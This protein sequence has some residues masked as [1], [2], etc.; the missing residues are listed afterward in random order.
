MT[1][2]VQR[3]PDLILKQELAKIWC[4][5]PDEVEINA[6]ELY[7]ATTALFIYE[8]TYSDLAERIS[9]VHDLTSTV[10]AVAQRGN[11]WGRYEYNAAQA[12]HYLATKYHSYI[13]DGLAILANLCNYPIRLDTTALTQYER[14]RRG[15]VLSL[16]L[17]VYTLSIANGDL[18]FLFCSKEEHGSQL[19]AS[20]VPCSSMSIE[21]V[22]FIEDEAPLMIAGCEIQAGGMVMPGFLWHIQDCVDL[23]EIRSLF[24][25]RWKRAMVIPVDKSM[26]RGIE[27]E[28][29]QE[30]LN[31]FRA[32]N[33]VGP[34]RF[35]WN[36]YTHQIPQSEIARHKRL[37]PEMQPCSISPQDM[38]IEAES[39]MVTV[40][41]SGFSLGQWIIRRA[42]EH[43]TIYHGRLASQDHTGNDALSCIFD[44]DGPCCIFTPFTSGGDIQA[45]TTPISWIV[46]RQ[47]Q[48]ES[49]HVLLHGEDL[50]KGRWSQDGSKHFRYILV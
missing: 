4:R 2:L 35:I 27:I 10:I 32:G 49:G 26:Q 48:I 38:G 1:F 23:R 36:L 25:A 41:R 17:C 44:V 46:T 31:T 22:D 40:Y 12:M 45:R 20:W 13:P 21:G 43:G 50:V 39:G 33:L 15:C 24:S 16:S 34:A 6:F 7:H 19:V 8:E 14:E 9:A 30:I 5:T 47:E 11:R 3:S 37:F 18:S 29:V 28:I 42:M